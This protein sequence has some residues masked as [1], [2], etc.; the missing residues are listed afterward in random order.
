MLAGGID[1]FAAHTIAGA[2]RVLS[3]NPGGID[4]IMSTIAFDDSRMLEFLEAVKQDA[5]VSG[6]PFLCLRVFRSVISDHFVDSMRATSIQLGAVDLIDIADLRGDEAQN[7][8]KAGIA[9]C[10]PSP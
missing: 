10:L 2:W 8:V 3:E 5:S 9:K 6:I 4:V 1:L 7:V